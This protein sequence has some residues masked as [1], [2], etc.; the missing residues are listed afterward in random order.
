MKRQLVVLALVVLLV[1]GCQPRLTEDLGISAWE[2]WMV[3]PFLGVVARAGLI[4][5]AVTAALAAVTLVC[6]A[7]YF[8]V[9]IRRLR[10]RGFPGLPLIGL[11]G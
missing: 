3:E 5:L 4:A 1:A 7:V 11:F 2:G 9:I 8:A 6:L 10:T